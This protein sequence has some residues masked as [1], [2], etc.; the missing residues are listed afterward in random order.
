[1]SNGSIKDT[2]VD[3]NNQP[4]ILCN[5]NDSNSIKAGFQ[6]IKSIVAVGNL[7]FSQKLIKFE[8]SNI[9]NDTLISM[10]INTQDLSNYQMNAFNDDETPIEEFEV[11]FKTVDIM[12]VTKLTVKKDSIYLYMVSGDTNIYVQVFGNISKSA[13]QNPINVIPI[14]PVDY[15]KYDKILYK[16]DETDPN[17]KIP[18]IDFAKACA[19]YCTL[20]CKYVIAI[21]YSKGILFKGILPCGN[22]GRVDPYGD[23]SNQI[24]N[25]TISDD[26]LLMLNQ[27]NIGTKTQ[28]QDVDKKPKLIIKKMED[29]CSI[30]INMLVIKAMS[31]INN[32]ATNNIIKMYL[33]ENKPLKIVSP[34]GCFGTFTFHIRDYV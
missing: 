14:I 23:C 18:A 27:L 15:I 9:T 25:V 10:V 20:K 32:L 16:R 1:M 13:N 28:T 11:G 8:R 17:I 22:I 6:M 2:N 31:K 19:A 7:T 21:G 4:I 24:N 5:F 29:L 12:K 30:K 34:L 26:I 3:N 33:E